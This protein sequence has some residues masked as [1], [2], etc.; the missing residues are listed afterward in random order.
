MPQY[1]LEPP[2]TKQE[3]DK[4]WSQLR[5]EMDKRG[6][7]FQE[8]LAKS[9]GVSATEL[10]KLKRGETTRKWG[11]SRMRRYADWLGVSVDSM[12]GRAEGTTQVQTPSGRQP[13]R[14]SVAYVR[15][16][17]FFLSPQELLRREMEMSKEWAAI[18]NIITTKCSSI[19]KYDRA[20]RLAQEV[21]KES[22]PHILRMIELGRSR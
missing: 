22:E 2:V 15:T 20:Q 3:L 19:V 13:G 21:L 1:S 10:S 14:E 7:R 18:S 12:L 9:V 8:E 5:Q 17:R 6:F 11:F 16:E 4:I